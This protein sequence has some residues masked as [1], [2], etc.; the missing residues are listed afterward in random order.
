MNA[1]RARLPR[2]DAGLSLGELVVTM[3]ITSLVLAVGA[4]MF[5]S[6]LQQSSF[7]R[8]KVNATSSARIA[9]ESVSRD[10][11]VAVRPTDATPAI[12]FAGA[13]EL[14]MYVSRGAS[15]GAT[16]PVP[17]KVWYWVNP[18]SGCLMRAS[19]VGTLSGGAYTW[20]A[21]SPRPT[22]GCVTAGRFNTD[23]SAL[24]TYYPL[25]TTSVPS[26][27][28]VVPTGTSSLTAAQRVTLASVT[29]T[30]RVSDPDATT[31]RPVVVSESVSMINLV[32]YL[33]SE[34]G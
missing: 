3:F 7:A 33:K 14:I 5:V 31:V 13:R 16:S 25:M 19:A 27:A 24:F 11:R 15:T 29:V 32:N 12:S 30:V 22:G 2:G 21:D 4:T 10:V 18:S 6:T 17:T 1:F 34:G 26:P 20:P 23:G 8:S 28:P 9:M